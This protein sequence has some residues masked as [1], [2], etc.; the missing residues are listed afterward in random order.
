MSVKLLVKSFSHA[1]RGIAYTARH[2]QNFRVELA[3]S[4]LVVLF[5]FLFRIVSIDWIIVLFLIAFVLVLELFNTVFERFIDMV[6][7]R[8]HIEVKQIKDML[9]AAVTIGAICA[10]TI[11]LIIFWPYVELFF[12]K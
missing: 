7:P 12:L 10:A 5:G 2:E 3:A 4:L 11:G 6:K 9:A 1:F 8:Y